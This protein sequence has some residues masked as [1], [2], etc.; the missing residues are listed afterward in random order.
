VRARV[1]VEVKQQP[2]E[3]AKEQTSALYL[4]IATLIHNKM[5]AFFWMEI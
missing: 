3:G 2:V 1:C 5:I 4:G